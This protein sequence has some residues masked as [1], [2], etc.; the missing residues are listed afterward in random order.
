[1]VKKIIAGFSII[2]IFILLNIFSRFLYDQSWFSKSTFKNDLDPYTIISLIVTTM[3]T[4]WLGLYVSKKI[5]EQRY[6]KEFIIS[7]LIRIEEEIKSLERKLSSTSTDLQSL[8]IKLN[9]INTYIERFAMTVEIINAESVLRKNILEGN[10]MKLYKK[11]TDLDG[12]Q[13]NI[14]D[15]IHHE[16]TKICTKFIVDTRAMI[17]KINKQ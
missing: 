11:T 1:M 8:I 17:L 13:L 16:I 7:D 9:K 5:T 4:I 3:V 10:Y 14:N 12:D 2:I 6:E 15:P